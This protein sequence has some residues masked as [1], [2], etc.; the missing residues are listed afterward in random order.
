MQPLARLALLLVLAACA[1][2]GATLASARPA[3][4]A[5]EGTVG[6][7]FTITLK[8]AQGNAV[9]TL[10][11]GDYTIT[12]KDLSEFHNFHLTGPGVNQ[13][14]VVEKTGTVTW[15]VHLASGMYTFQC[16]PHSS[17]MKGTVRVG[18]GGTTTV[19]TTTTTT[20]GGGTA[21]PKPPVV[22]GTVGPGTTIRLTKGGKR[23]K[24]LKAGRYTFRIADRAKAH[25]FVLEKSKGGKFERAIT[26]VPFVGTK[27]MVVTLTRGSWEFYCA[28]HESTMHG[29]FTVT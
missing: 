25:N 22:V 23:V 12:V 3:A 10:P 9:T 5:L 8:D 29:N 13:A 4:T 26:S 1:A 2:A 24:S 21:P 7:D 14:T 20:S 18:T 6:P 15:N 27:S 11:E 28:P 17:Q 16:D 19:T